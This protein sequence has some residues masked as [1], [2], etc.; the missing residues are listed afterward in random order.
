MD[1]HPYDTERHDIT[2]HK[3]LEV[4]PKRKSL[5]KRYRFSQEKLKGVLK[6]KGFA[7]RYRFSHE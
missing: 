6:D 1:L 5:T 4:V 7:K 3:K 2:C